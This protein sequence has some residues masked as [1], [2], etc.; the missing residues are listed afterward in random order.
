MEN[1]SPSNSQ[2]PSSSG[3]SFPETK[4]WWQS[5]A[6]WGCLAGL[7]VS[8]LRF[9]GHDISEA[10]AGDIS[11]A[12]YTVMGTVSLVLALWGRLRAKHVLT[13][14]ASVLLAVL[15][16]GE[17]AGCATNTGNASKDR[18]GRVTNEV[19]LTAGR[20]IGSGA[21]S[22]IS[23]GVQQA[24]GGKHWDWS[25]SAS[26]GL[27]TASTSLATSDELRRLV[28]AFSGPQAA[29]IKDAIEVPLAFAESPQEVRAIA[30]AT[31]A[32][33]DQA[34]LIATGSNGAPRK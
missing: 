4:P 13:S 28:D 3:A 6:V 25:A 17:L 16:V 14:T 15:L 9:F 23:D 5:K 22:A 20:V 34:V 2:A 19:L 27:W 18:A 11:D 29:A 26:H 24:V 12:I 32:G 8:A 7:I 21:V 30:A 10:D 1:T 33:L 31:A